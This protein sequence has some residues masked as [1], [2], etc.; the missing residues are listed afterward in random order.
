MVKLE[1]THTHTHTHRDTHTHKHTRT[2]THTQCIIGTTTNVFNCL[3]IRK[4][5]FLLHRKTKCQIV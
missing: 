1:F 4:I 2:Y 5:A 3:I